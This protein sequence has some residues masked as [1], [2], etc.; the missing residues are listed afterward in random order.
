MVPTVEGND[1]RPPRRLNLC[2]ESEV[3]SE[4]DAR[5]IADAATDYARRLGWDPA[6]ETGD[7]SREAAEDVLGHLAPPD[8]AL[9]MDRYI[10]GKSIA[11]LAA[12]LG[13][14]ENA[15]AHRLSRAR[16][17]ARNGVKPE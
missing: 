13:C 6:P 1:A 14:S 3:L 10:E 12:G 16:Q 7:A 9:L 15:I 2:S 5:Q 11:E 17:R 8:R 4:Q